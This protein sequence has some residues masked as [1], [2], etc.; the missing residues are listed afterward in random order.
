MIILI[1]TS[2]GGLLPTL[3]SR[4][5]RLSFAP[6]PPE[7]MAEFLVSHKGMSQE[8]ASLVASLAMGSLG[9]ALNPEM[10]AFWERRRAWLEKIDSLSRDDPRGWMALAEE[11]ASDREES[12]RFLEWLQSWYRDILICSATGK[13]Q[14]MAN[15]DMAKSIEGQAGLHGPERI[16]FLLSEAVRTEARIHRNFN[17]R[18]ALEDLLRRVTESGF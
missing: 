8:K 9:R 3:L 15:Q 1:S 14:G 4:C 16:L 13:N 18:M 17:R 10:E 11:L 6:L 5:L 12:L 2:P 7:E